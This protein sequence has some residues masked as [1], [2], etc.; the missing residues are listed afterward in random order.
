[1]EQNPNLR[2]KTVGQVMNE[3]NRKMGDGTVGSS[4]GSSKAAEPEAKKVDLPDLGK[5]KPWADIV[6]DPEWSKLDDATKA[7]AKAAYFDHW[8]APH[9]GGRAAQMRQQFLD[10]KDPTPTLMDKAGDLVDRGLDAVKSVLPGADGTEPPLTPEEIEQA[11]KPALA[12]DVRGRKVRKP[13]TNTLPGSVMNNAPEQARLETDSLAPVRPEVRNAFN[14]QWDASTPEQRAAMSKQEGVFGQL[15]REREGRFT[16]SDELLKDVPNNSAVRGIDPRVEAR[17]Q[18]LIAKGEDPRFAER[19]AMEGAQAGV[20]PGKEVDFIQKQYGS[21]G[22]SDFDFET[23][24][25]FKDQLGANN[26]LVR[27]TVKAALGTG[28]AVLGINQFLSDAMGADEYSAF[29]KKGN[30]WARSKEGAIGDKGTFLERNLEGAINSI[31]QQLPW[32]VAGAATGG[33]AIPLVAMGMQSF[34]QEY[35]DGRAAGQDVQQA[36]TRASIFAAFE[37]LGEKFG[38]GSQLKALRGAAHGMPNDQII[39]LLGEAL[40]KEVPGELFTT[41]GQF[42]AD[43]WMPQGYALNPNATVDDFVKQVADTIAQTIMQSVVMGAGTTGAST[44]RRFMS[45]KGYGD[46]VANADAE[47]ARTQALNKWNTQGVAPSQYAQ[48]GKTEP[49]VGALPENLTED[50]RIEPTLGGQPTAPV[51][52][53]EPSPIDVHPTSQTADGIVTYLANQAGVPIDTVLPKQQ[54]QQQTTAPESFS[55][56]DVLDFAETRYQQLRQK[57]D[58]GV[59][60]VVTD[61]DLSHSDLAVR[62]TAASVTGHPTEIDFTDK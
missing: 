42:A 34:G 58:G 45:E 3:I 15:A 54:T 35:T 38:L 22:K 7:Q 51:T 47:N 62:V 9:A 46:G 49:K 12:G 18:A 14:A 4:S 53:A 25:F 37:V 23:S 21:I 56:Q 24:H 17:R 60:S 5:A 2:G 31:G 1:M 32:M 50:G 8:I 27:G 44:A 61:D 40:K 48:D 11:S 59:Q 41:T 36:A 6:K 33:T 10:M 55:D 52:T 26:P 30:D 29:L 19:A 57:R 43:K 28:K 13:E 16:R 20:I 39:K